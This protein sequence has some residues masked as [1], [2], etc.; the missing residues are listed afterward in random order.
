MPVV[1]KAFM[2]MTRLSLPTFL[3]DANIQSLSSK[4]LKGKTL[5]GSEIYVLS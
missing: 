1:A 2:L 3:E 4:T 5:K